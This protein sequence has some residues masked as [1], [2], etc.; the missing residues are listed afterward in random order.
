MIFTEKNS[1]IKSAVTAVKFWKNL[2]LAGVGSDLLVFDGFDNYKETTCVRQ[3]IH[4]QFNIHGIVPKENSTLVAI[5]GG[6]RITI[7]SIIIETEITI[8]LEQSWAV[9]DWIYNICWLS[10]EYQLSAIYGHNV[11]S[12]W[13]WKRIEEVDTASCEDKCMLSSAQLIGN[14]WEEIVVLSGTMHSEILIW[15]AAGAKNESKSVIHRLKGHKGAIFS[16]FYNPS[17]RQISSTSDDRSVCIWD[18][19]I[20]SPYESVESWKNATVVLHLSIYSHIS[21]VWKS[22]ILSNQKIVSIGEDSM[23]CINDG[24]GETIKHESHQGGG[25]WSFECNEDL[26]LIVTGGADGGISL[27]PLDF[28]SLHPKQFQVPSCNLRKL[29]LLSKGRVIAVTDE[30][31]ILIGSNQQWIFTKKDERIGTYCLLKVSPCK[32][33]VAIYSTHNRAMILKVNDGPEIM[34]EE[35]IYKEIDKNRA[36]SMHWVKENHLVF[37]DS[38]GNLSLWKFSFRNENQSD[39]EK[40]TS[41]ILPSSKEPWTTAALI[42][43]NMF[44]CGDRGGSIHV[45]NLEDKSFDI[46][47]A[48]QTLKCVHGRLGVGSLKW[49]DKRVWSTGRDGTL[50]QYIIKNNELQSMSME[51]IN[52]E[53]AANIIQS[54]DIGTLVIGF[55]EVNFVVWSV[56]ERRILFMVPCGG[57]HRSWSCDLDSETLYFAYLQNKTAHTITCLLKE[58]VQPAILEGFHTSEVNSIV[59]LPINSNKVWLV[60]GGEDTTVRVTDFSKR[61][62]TKSVFRSHVS[63]VRVVCAFPMPSQDSAFVFTAGGRAQIKVWKVETVVLDNTT[64]VSTTELNSLMIMDI[65]RRKRTHVPEN[66]PEPRCMDLNVLSCA[67]NYLLVLMA[68]S[69]AYLRIFEY[70]IEKNKLILRNSL[71]YSQHCQL[72]VGSVAWKNGFHAAFTAATDG[73][74]SFWEVDSAEIETPFTILP[75]HQSGIN[76]CDWQ[77]LPNDRLLLVTGGDDSVVSVSLIK[78]VMTTKMEA[79]LLHRKDDFRSHCSQITGIKIFKGYFITAGLD[80]RIHIFS[81]DVGT[82]FC[83]V[84]RI[85]RIS[86]SISDIHG[87][88]VWHQNFFRSTVNLCIYGAGFEVL[89]VPLE[90]PIV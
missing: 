64:S 2:L 9:D 40:I 63:S 75:L 44:I 37:C 56:N 29:G 21:R 22:Q 33:F 72:K 11:L 31:F 3:R 8:E 1:F 83:E 89:Q 52:V 32:N 70:N 60:S 82:D 86:S 71:W 12:L 67:E 55:R 84:H 25:I 41:L 20:K 13:D 30:G 49:L 53:W 57:G 59:K 10:K 74:V 5:Y 54:E 43:Q 38:S 24:Q 39:L 46:K 69:D 81:W 88:E 19:N 61:F 45:Y 51:K 23:L 62:K 34:L 16:V 7:V 79:L 65:E 14:K 85:R 28:P 66:V 78:K 42:V 50:R 80:Q 6:K 68:C 90:Y 87:L 4:E 18:V 36:L 27:W 15:T 26:K 73:R 47:K 76:A 17:C 58:V 48:H 35:E 77:D